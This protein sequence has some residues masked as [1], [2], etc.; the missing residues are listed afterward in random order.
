LLYF[1]T[2]LSVSLCVFRAPLHLLMNLIKI[3]KDWF[4]SVLTA[5]ALRVLSNNESTDSCNIR[6][7]FLR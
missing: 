1:V 4:D 3:L 6:F 5:E 7:R 2:K